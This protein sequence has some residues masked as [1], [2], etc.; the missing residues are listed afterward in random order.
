MPV[1]TSQLPKALEKIEKAYGAGS[2]RAGDGKPSVGRISTGAMELDYATG[3][4]IPIGRWSHFYGGYSSA[5]TLTSW[6]I[7][8]EAQKLGMTCAYYNLEKQYEPD[9]LVKRGIN[10]KDLI[11]VEGTT[12]EG[13]GAKLEALLASVH[14]H[15]LDS[16]AVGVSI[17]E[18]GSDIE[19]NHMGLQA[20]SWAK[21]LRRANE[22]FDDTENTVIMINQVRD[23]F[24]R[25]GGE[26][27]PGG[28]LIDYISSLNLYFRRS[29]WLYRDDDGNLDSDNKQNKGL[30]D[31][32]EPEGIE[33]QVR[34]QKSRVCQPFRTAR[35]RLDFKTIEFD[36]LWSYA[37]AAEYFEVITKTSAGRFELADGTKIH[38]RSKLREAIAADPSL[39]QAIRDRML[40]AA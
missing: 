15:I 34:V 20:R 38:G 23:V 21:V 17:Q 14:V 9:L 25:G 5:K 29:S 35:L 36:E 2:I 7:V 13:T 37:K 39:Q 33:F 19:D 12:I 32:P 18:L 6:N 16:L 4:G 26:A 1:D 8:R 11:V 31:D 30:A 28:R 27:P 24:G 10:V 22:R 40:K 3:G